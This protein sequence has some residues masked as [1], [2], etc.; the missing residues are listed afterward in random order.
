MLASLLKGPLEKVVFVFTA[1]SFFVI[2]DYYRR[3]TQVIPISLWTSRVIIAARKSGFARMGEGGGGGIMLLRVITA[4]FS[5]ET[6]TLEWGSTQLFIR[7]RY[8]QSNS[9]EHTVQ[10]VKVSGIQEQTNTVSS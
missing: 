1:Q 2:V 6:S 5:C 10:I 3:R 9:A 4:I 8:L 7:L